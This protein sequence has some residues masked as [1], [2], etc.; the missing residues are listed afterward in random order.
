MINY[1][2]LILV[3]IRPTHD[4]HTSWMNITHN[5]KTKAF[6]SS[7]H[8]DTEHLESCL[9]VFS[10]KEIHLDNQLTTAQKKIIENYL[11]EHFSISIDGKKKNLNV[12]TIE[13]NFAETF[14]HLNPIKH[15][16]KISNITIDNRLLIRQFPNQKNMVQINY[17][18]SK[19]S[20]LLNNKKT[21]DSIFF[22][23]K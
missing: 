15:Q 23:D 13:V 6:N 16:K 20:M 14:I 1:I 11:I 7:W 2:I 22:N 5:D 3:L 8:T 10:D 12:G 17:E 9:S 4:F 21:S 19:Y 18:G